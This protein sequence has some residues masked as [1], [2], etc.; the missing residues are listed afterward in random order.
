MIVVPIY[1]RVEVKTKW[2]N[3]R[4]LGQKASKKEMVYSKWVVEEGL[5]NKLFTKG[6]KRAKGNQQRTIQSPRVHN[7]W[8][9]SPCWAWRDGEECVWPT[10]SCSSQSG[11]PEMSYPLGQ[12]SL[13][14]AGR[15]EV[16][17]EIN[18]MPLFLLLPIFSQCLPLTKPN[19]W[20]EAREPSVTVQRGQILGS[21][22]GRR[23]W[24]VGL[25][26]HETLNIMPLS[27]E[28]DW[29]LL[30][31]QGLPLCL[32]LNQIHNVCYIL[33]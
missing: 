3:E 18:A 21:R 8:V 1:L 4:V 5:K 13:P 28:K 26:A 22:K 14:E 31:H 24:R 15:E 32:A 12:A 16:E 23:T 20:P 7:S 19:R 30:K 25:G 10:G 17:E 9:L 2:A 33:P 6:R 29:Q 11:Q 27:T